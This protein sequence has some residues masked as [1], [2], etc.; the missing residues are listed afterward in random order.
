MLAPLPAPLS[1]HSLRPLP[2]YPPALSL[3]LALALALVP[4]S[5]PYPM[6]PDPWPLALISAAIRPL[7]S[8]PLPPTPSP[9]GLL[10][11][12]LLLS[13]LPR[14]RR[15]HR[16][17]A[18]ALVDHSRKVRSLEDFSAEVDGVNARLLS[19]GHTGL[20]MEEVW[21]PSTHQTHT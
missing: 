12:W 2:P 20:I 14:A 6:A 15:A 19:Y 17:A 3:A 11:P 8:A 18:D 10:P 1:L 5:A 9:P 13:A 16:E 4:L 7:A 21:L